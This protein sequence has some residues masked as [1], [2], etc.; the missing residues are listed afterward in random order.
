M[1]LV[2]SVT[3]GKRQITM[4]GQEVHYSASRAG[5]IDFSWTMRGNHVL[6]VVAHASPPLSAAPGFRQYDFFVDGQS[7]FELPKVY[8]L[9][10]RGASQAQSRVPGN[11]SHYAV[12]G[13]QSQEDVDLQSAIQASIAESRRHL[14]AK[15]G[16]YNDSYNSSAGSSG[17]A[18]P[19]PSPA[20]QEQAAVVDLLNFGSA[21]PAPY[22]DAAAAGALVPVASQYGAP[23]HQYGAPAPVYAPAVPAYAPAVPAYG[24]APAPPAAVQYTPAPVYAPAAPVYAPAPSTPNTAAGPSSA[25]QYPSGE[26]LSPGVTSAASAPAAYGFPVQQPMHN[27]DDPFAPKVPTQNELLTSVL[28]LYGDQQAAPATPG[29]PAQPNFQTPQTAPLA[30]NGHVNLSMNAPLAIANEEEVA[31]K[32]DFEKAMSNLVNFDD[33]S[34]P[35]DKD[36]QAAMIKK[37]GEQSTNLGNKSRGLPPVANNMVGSGATLTQIQHVKPVRCSL[38]ALR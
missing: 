31:P 12:A 24:Y 2:W 21:A 23:T 1:T 4:D 22:H 7:F 19:A 35:A 33:I 34:A 20:P 29:A 36:I 16:R 37:Q 10:L 6:K 30:T 15:E 18:Y 5:I 11:L 27:Y 8:E 3:S 28:G 9:G 32:S 38:P 14:Q 26:L 25:H 17:G 13:S